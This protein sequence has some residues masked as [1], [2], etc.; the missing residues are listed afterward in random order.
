MIKKRWSAALLGAAAMLLSLGALGQQR[1]TGWY[2]GGSL[3][4][5]DLGPD[6]DIALKVFGG[7]Q[8]NPAFS[9]EFGYTDLGDASVRGTTVEANALELVGV[10]RLPLSDR[11][12]SLYGLLGIAKVEVEASV[13]GVRVSDDSTELTIGLGMQ[14]DFS[15]QIALR[16]QWQRYDTS[17]EIDVLSVGFLY[18]F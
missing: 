11:R 7:Y 13:F 15:P 2:A 6:E 10:A 1:L 17:Q 16:G 12:F 14:Y 18:R 9:V 3:G 8:V 5:A 4:N